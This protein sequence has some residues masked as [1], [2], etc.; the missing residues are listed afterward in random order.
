MN[1]PHPYNI[2]QLTPEDW[3]LLKTIRLEALQAHPKLFCPSQDEFAFGEAQWRDR[4]SNPAAVNF[5]VFDGENII[6]LCGIIRARLDPQAPLA[7]MVAAYLK[8]DY[9][10]QGLSKYMYQARLDWARAQK[11]ITEVEVEHR[12]TNAPARGAHQAFGFAFKEK[13]LNTWRDGS[14]LEVEIYSLKL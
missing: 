11:N 12:S 6:G 10:K 13:R 9:R 3:A 5:G 7:F 8:A 4:L 2:R 14:Q 1:I